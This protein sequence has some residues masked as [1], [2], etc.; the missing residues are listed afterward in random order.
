M[1]YLLITTSLLTFDLLNLLK[2]IPLKITLVFLFL[3]QSLPNISL[4]AS[5][6]HP[7]L[8]GSNLLISLFLIIEY[9]FILN[10]YYKFLEPKKDKQKILNIFLAY[11]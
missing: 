6:L 1:L 11:L 2:D 5:L 9:N 7:N 10:F 4:Q 3:K 8:Y